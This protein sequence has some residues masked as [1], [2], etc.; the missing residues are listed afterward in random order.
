[1][2]IKH[3]KLKLKLETA[4][5]VG[6]QQNPDDAADMLRRRADGQL[7]IPGTGFAG[8]FRNHLIRIVPAMTRFADHQI[9]AEELRDNTDENDAVLLLENIIYHLMGDVHPD[10]DS[11]S[12]H[13]TGKLRSD[14]H[15]FLREYSDRRASRLII[16]DAVVHTGDTHIRDG[17]GID[18]ITGTASRQ[19]QSKFEIE[20]LPVGTGVELL[21]ELEDYNETDEYLVDLLIAE[22]DAGRIRVGGNTR[23]GMGKLILT[24]VVETQAYDLEAPQQMMQYLSREKSSNQGTFNPE[25]FSRSNVFES[26]RPVAGSVQSWIKISFDLAI[27]GFFLT[28]DTA[29]AVGDKFDLYSSMSPANRNGRPFYAG[30][31]LRGVL[32]SSM[33]RNAR[34]ITNTQVNNGDDFLYRCAASDPFVTHWS[35]HTEGIESTV[36]RLDRA[37]S[38]LKEKPEYEW[39]DLSERL[40]GTTIFGSRLMV[41]DAPLKAGTEATWKKLDFVAIDRFTGGAADSMKFDAY[42]LWQPTFSCEIY[43]ESPEN[44]EVGGLLQALVDLREGFVSVGYGSAKG[45]GDAT[46][47]NLNLSLGYSHPEALQLPSI[48]QAT[49]KGFWFEETLTSLPDTN[50]IGSWIEAVS[51]YKDAGKLPAHIYPDAYWNTRAA[52]LYPRQGENA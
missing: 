25:T 16:N 38:E 24:D 27:Q 31:G 17:V 48:G 14:V 23:R 12:S 51:N 5:H 50:I 43:L 6:T 35:Q 29:R 49:E 28:N 20:T 4:L 36:S 30:S 22:L 33:E 44:W 37:D 39:F 26:Y 15:D 9:V 11:L 34:T 1:M 32:R 7:V 2:K 40:F 45:F 10:R 52:L 3:Y 8:A 47:E 21:L 46:I 41:A 18:R 13:D 19:A 42:A